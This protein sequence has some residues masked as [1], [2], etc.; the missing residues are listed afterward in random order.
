[1]FCEH[2]ESFP[3][4]NTLW[5]YFGLEFQGDRVQHSK[6]GNS[7]GKHGT[8]SQKLANHILFI[9]KEQRDQ[10]GNGARLKTLKLCSQ[11]HISFSRTPHSK[12]SINFPK[13]TTN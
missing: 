9:H 2:L 11:G 5:V 3:I 6:E 1:M 13:R 4:S 8:Q 10:T 7:W 12:D